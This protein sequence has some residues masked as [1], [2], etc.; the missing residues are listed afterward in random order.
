MS[1]LFSGNRVESEPNLLFDKAD[2]SAVHKQVYWGL[3]RFG[4]YEKNIR[5][6]RVVELATRETIGKLDGIVDGLNKGVDIM[7]GGMSSFFR[8]EIESVEK[9]LSPSIRTVD[10]VSTANQISTSY[11]PREVDVVLS[12]IPFTS[13]YFKNTP[14]YRLKASL[15]THGFVSQMVTEHTIA[16]LRWSYVNLASAVFAKAGGVPWVLESEMKNTDI[17]IGVAVSQHVSQRTR[18]GSL[19]RYVGFVNVFDRFGRWLFFEGTARPY[20]KGK[21]FEQLRELLT[22][23]FERYKAE[24]P[25]KPPPRNVV[26]HYYKRYSEEEKEDVLKILSEVLGNFKVAF[27]SIDDS[28]PYRLYDFDRADAAFPM[29][30]Y[31]YLN[32][33]EI[34]LSTTGASEQAARRMG[35]PRILHIRVNQHPERFL[36]LDDVASQVLSLT[37]LDWATATPMVREPVTMQFS[38]EIAYLTGAISEG[39]WVGLTEPRVNEILSKRTW[40]I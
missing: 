8:C 7:P 9:F 20:V 21:N 40:F 30:G 4:P 26:I 34:L 5:K 16:N 13:R 38:Q 22:K 14:Y 24:S 31:V 18:A 10:Y 27:V 37:K 25:E 1:F 12:F 2:S 3:R 39:E 23:A 29:G 17:I 28:H 32:D 35:T 36:S 11:E 33:D 15:T 6:V 19:A